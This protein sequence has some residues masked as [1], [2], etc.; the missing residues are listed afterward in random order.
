VAS[1]EVVVHFEQKG[2]ELRAVE[3]GR[4]GRLPVISALH[5]ALFALGIVVS[6]YQVRAANGG[7]VE[8]LVLERRD[9]GSIDGQLSSATRAAILPIAMEDAG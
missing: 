5:R 9:G 2:S 4:R 1:R 8:R 3:I 7:L 6:T